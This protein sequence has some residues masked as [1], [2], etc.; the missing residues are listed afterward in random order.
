M[1]T[2]NGYEG[3]DEYAVKLIRHKARQLVG[4]AGFVE[5]DRADLEQE[6]MIDLL[7]RLPRF[8]PSRAKRETFMS[9][10]V[11]H[12]VATIIESRKA[13]IRDYRLC[14]QS[15]DDPGPEEDGRAADSPPL[16]DQDAYLRETRGDA[17]TQEELQDLRMDVASALADL[18]PDLR[19]LCLRLATA[20][21]TEVSKET[22]IPRGTVYDALKK[23][24]ARFE[25]AGLAA[26]L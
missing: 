17:L 5:A 19:R 20:S 12:R 1:G 21:V 7:R 16:L 3:L 23:A 6:M 26:Y 8:D 22:G 13:G 24:R 15:I 4:K 10:I 9:R 18:P 11:T 14:M 25:R 2:Q